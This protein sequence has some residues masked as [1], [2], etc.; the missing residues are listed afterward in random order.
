MVVFEFYHPCH[1]ASYTFIHAGVSDSGSQCDHKA[2]SNTTQLLVLLD[3]IKSFYDTENP[4]SV[5]SMLFD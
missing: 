1:P 4:S 2:A 3:Q 5:L